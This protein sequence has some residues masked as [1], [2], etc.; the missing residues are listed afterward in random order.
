MK[1]KIV[2][3][4][5]LFCTAT[6]LLYGAKAEEKKAGSAAVKGVVQDKSGQTVANATVYLVPA[7]DV[8][9][10]RKVP[11]TEIKEDS[12][13]DEPMEDNLAVNRDNYRKGIT[14]AKGEFTISGVPDA[15]YFLYVEPSDGEHLPG[16]DMANKSV[17]VAEMTSKPLKILV[18][19][20]IPQNAKYVGSSK[21]LSCHTGYAFEKKTLHKLGISVVGK[22]SGLQDYSRFPHFN[23]GLN[24]L[25]AGKKF[26]FYGFD[27]SRG[28]DKYMI[29]EKMP[30]DASS[31]SFSATFFKDADGELKFKIENMKDPSD[32]PRTYVVEM[33]YGGGLYKQRYLYRV[34]NAHPPVGDAH[35]PFLQ[36]NPTGDESYNDRTRKPW[37]DYHGDWLFN[38]TTKKLTDPP[39]K[40]SFE[41]E[42]ASCHFT[43][44]SLTLTTG[45]G[46]V[47]GAVNDPNGELDIDGDGTPNELNIGCEVCHGPGSA[48]VA[49]PANKKAATIVSPGKL[50][51]ERAT[52]ICN[53]CHS[54]PQGYLKNDQ[55]VSR[56]NRMLIP[57][58]TRNEYLA[59][60]TTREDA[61]QKDFWGD[62]IHSKSHHQQ[63][64][65]L[66]RSKKYINGK[67][68]MTC[69]NCHDPHGKSEVKH[70]LKAPVRD[71]KNTLCASCHQNASDM[72][73]HTAKAVGAAHEGQIFCV[74]CHVPKTMQTGAGLG[75]GLVRK[76]G[77][78][79]WMNDITSHIFD[80]PRKNN[81][82]VKGIEPGKAMPTPYTNA[83]GKCHNVDNL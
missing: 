77:K 49:S 32:A 66:V 75:K 5:T 52:V 57:G 10:M 74:D 45:G 37:R 78:N 28:F 2:F 69:I 54:R 46:F 83:C 12:P 14:N 76:D 8:E 4:L 65:D 63:G 71:E 23:D 3:F 81:V 26:Y 33:T 82:G 56:E 51:A 24:K 15:R 1:T 73:A 70:Q 79:Y 39:K 30:S 58:I 41:I 62:K 35:F 59:N 20:K 48:H 55:P 43:G 50:A 11:I 80:V 7:A 36:Y 42:C 47:A 67:Q 13:N 40:K 18:S 6:L 9:A 53:Q 61:A 21:C 68:T 72:G 31:V 34:G 19:G 60:H 29:S 22:P 64:T 27:K 16:G 25:M 38:E 44:Y 17:S